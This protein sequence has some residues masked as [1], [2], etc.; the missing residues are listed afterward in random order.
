MPGFPTETMTR[1]VELP[2][3]LLLV[4]E[5]ATVKRILSLIFRLGRVG[6]TR[7][8]Q[9]DLPGLRWRDQFQTFNCN[10]VVPPET[11]NTTLAAADVY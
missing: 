1:M 2:L 5:T 3:D 6:E 11:T 8:P 7:T 4:P 10:F 9:C